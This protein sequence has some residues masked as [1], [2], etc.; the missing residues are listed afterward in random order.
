MQFV[1]PPAVAQLSG[2]LPFGN[3]RNTSSLQYLLKS[4][5]VAVGAP[6]G[7]AVGAAVGVAVAHSGQLP[8][9]GFEHLV[10][11]GLLA[12]ALFNAGLFGSE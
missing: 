10:V 3:S 6:V 7:V 9:L 1:V 4:A 2:S 5:G 8:H 11:Q 12:Q